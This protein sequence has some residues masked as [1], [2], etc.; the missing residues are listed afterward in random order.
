MDVFHIFEHM[1]VKYNVDVEEISNS[2]KN[3]PAS[4]IILESKTED[5]T[6]VTGDV[7]AGVYQIMDPR[8]RPRG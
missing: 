6:K 5:P 2:Y 3:I 4:Q 8:L 1:D 7:K